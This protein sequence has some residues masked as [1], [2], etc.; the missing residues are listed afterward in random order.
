MVLTPGLQS[1]YQGLSTRLYL[2]RFIQQRGLII[3]VQANKRD[4]KIETSHYANA[5]Q[6]SA[7][8]NRV[9]WKMAGNTTHADTY[10][11]EALLTYIMWEVIYMAR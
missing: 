9:K 4:R 11:R 2:L 3:E 6:L 1:R 7:K 5:S 10:R 8:I